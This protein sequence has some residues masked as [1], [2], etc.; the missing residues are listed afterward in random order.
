MR[1]RYIFKV[2]CRY[3]T[4]MDEFL[5][6]RAAV[7]EVDSRHSLAPCEHLPLVLTDSDAM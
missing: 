6:K 7:S 4:V 2:K 3:L 1:K 5:R